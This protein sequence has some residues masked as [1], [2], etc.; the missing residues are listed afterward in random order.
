M[1]TC[2]PKWFT[3]SNHCKTTLIHIIMYIVYSE[4]ECFSKWFSCLMQKTNNTSNS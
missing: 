2:F 3:K 1:F 4:C